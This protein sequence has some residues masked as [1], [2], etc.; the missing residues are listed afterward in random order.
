MSGGVRW[1]GPIRFGEVAANET[2]P[3]GGT[4]PL[5][6]SQTTLDGSV[7]VTATVGYRLSR[8]LRA[9]LAIAYNPSQL[10]SHITSDAEGVEDVTVDAPVSQFLVEGGVLAQLRRWQA[11]RVSPFLT[12]GI[13]YLRQLN[14]GRTLV[15]TGQAYYFGGGVYYVRAAARPRRLKATGVRA[16]LRALF[17]RDGVAPDH[18]VRGA[19]AITA[20]VF[21]RF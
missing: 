13:G 15:E 8:L 9:E 10:S 7:G 20:S 1:I 16:D 4:R 3:G 12:A 18:T 21:A 19:P 5:F 2:T 6:K 17:L 14:D 11:G